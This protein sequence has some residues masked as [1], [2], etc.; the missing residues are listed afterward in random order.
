MIW[1]LRPASA[2]R[3]DDTATGTVEVQCNNNRTLRFILARSLFAHS[4]VTVSARKTS[5]TATVAVAR[6]VVH[7]CRFRPFARSP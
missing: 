1:M 2:R 4:V 3:V 6:S 7:R 5:S